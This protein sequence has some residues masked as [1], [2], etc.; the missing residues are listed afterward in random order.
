MTLN[1]DRAI[2]RL[3]MV[4]AISGVILKNNYFLVSVDSGGYWV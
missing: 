1:T 3:E 4:N 2:L